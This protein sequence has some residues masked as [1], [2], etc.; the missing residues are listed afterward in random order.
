MNPWRNRAIKLILIAELL[1]YYTRFASFPFNFGAIH[2]FG[3]LACGLFD[4]L[5]ICMI[6][7]AFAA[8]DLFIVM[9]CL[10]LI[11]SFIVFCALLEYACE[12]QLFVRAR[13]T[14][15]RNLLQQT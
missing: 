10:T 2:Y 13:R 7:L 1:A 11:N 9:T 5:I 4:N 14:W 8:F 6:L 12:L 15:E 3:I